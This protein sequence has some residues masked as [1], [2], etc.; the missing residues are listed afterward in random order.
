MLDLYA[1][2]GAL[3]IEA[4]SRGARVA[5]LIDRDKEALTAIE[6]NLTTTGFTDRARVERRVIA[7]ELPNLV[8]GTDREPRFDIVF[9]DP[10]YSLPDAEL[11]EVL[12]GLRA[13]EWLSGSALVVVER[14]APTWAPPKGWSTCW[15]RKY[16]DTLISIV[17]V[18]P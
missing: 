13:A 18:E 3:A 5:L 11:V 9:V 12:E 10:P 6:Q 2:S 8:E 14:P 16:G 7:G 4:L 1:G 17:H 15:Q